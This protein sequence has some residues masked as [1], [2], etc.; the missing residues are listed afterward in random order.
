MPRPNI[1]ILRVNKNLLRANNA[2]TL[3]LYSMTSRGLVY[4]GTNVR[5]LALL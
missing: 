4:H 5:Y 1:I 2:I 3:P